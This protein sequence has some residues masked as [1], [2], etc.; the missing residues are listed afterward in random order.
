[1]IVVR[2][3]RGDIIANYLCI[4]RLHACAW[5]VHARDVQILNLCSEC[6]IIHDCCAKCAGMIILLILTDLLSC[7]RMQ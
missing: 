1:M 4:V 6:V 7:P 2:S 5:Q 3:A